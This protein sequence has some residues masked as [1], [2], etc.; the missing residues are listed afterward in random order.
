MLLLD[1]EEGTIGTRVIDPAIG[2][3]FRQSLVIENRP[4]AG[5]A[6]LTGQFPNAFPEG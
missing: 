2:E 3:L 6:D 1:F 5:D 4:G